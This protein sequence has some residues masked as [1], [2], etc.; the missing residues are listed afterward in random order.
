MAELVTQADLDEGRVYPPLSKIRETSTHLSTRLI[1][2]AYKEK[3]AFAY[4]E[5]ADKRAF[6]KQHQYS[7]EYDDFLPEVYEWPEEQ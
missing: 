6:I 7:P 5:P 2:Y 3:L 4:P 1:E